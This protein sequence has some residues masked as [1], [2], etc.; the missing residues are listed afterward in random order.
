MEDHDYAELGAPKG[1]NSKKSK[2][3][4]QVKQDKT[5][6]GTAALKPPTRDKRKGDV[7]RTSSTYGLKD[8]EKVHRNGKKKD[9][10]ESLEIAPY[11]TIPRKSDP[12]KKQNKAP[13]PNGSVKH[14]NGD[15]QSRDKSPHTDVHNMNGSARK[16]SKEMP[17]KDFS[18]LYAKVSKRGNGDMKSTETKVTLKE[19]KETTVNQ[20]GDDLSQLYA[21]VKK[22]GRKQLP[23][24]EVISHDKD[25]TTLKTNDIHNSASKDGEKPADEVFESNPYTDIKR[26]TSYHGKENIGSP[27][28]LAKRGSLSLSFRSFR[29]QKSDVTDE[30]NESLTSNSLYNLIPEEPDTPMPDIELFEEAPPLPPENAVLQGQD[31]S[32]FQPENANN[33][34]STEI[35]VENFEDEGYKE[36]MRR[37]DMVKKKQETQKRRVRFL[38][39]TTV[40]LFVVLLIVIGVVVFLLMEGGYFDCI[41]GKKSC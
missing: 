26:R 27:P 40:L 25:D 37:R 6:N 9:S 17:E 29:S 31:N 2:Q 22:S 34:Y 14:T 1:S 41:L 21:E 11:A 23:Q 33:I 10:P 16:D 35:D 28:R 5:P 4:K 3:G 18:G 36:A 13:S 24:Q 38:V 39:V 30:G 19:Q 15:V 12:S 7:R 20:Q 32:A 8:S